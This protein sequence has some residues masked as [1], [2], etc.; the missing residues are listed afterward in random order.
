MLAPSSLL[1]SPTDLRAVVCLSSA[2][3]ANDDDVADDEDDCGTARP[4]YPGLQFCAS[5]Y[6]DRVYLYTKVPQPVPDC[7]KW[8]DCLTG[9]IRGAKVCVEDFL[10]F[11]LHWW[12]SLGTVSLT[13]PSTSTPDSITAFEGKQLRGCTQN[14]DLYFMRQTSG[15]CILKRCQPLDL[16]A[17]AD[18]MVLLLCALSAASFHN[19][20]MEPFCRHQSLRLPISESCST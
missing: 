19:S 18:M 20:N 3:D 16:L 14:Y 6:T 4:V 5:Q 9:L 17:A 10:R 13:A 11:I 1:L 8:D 7:T 2:A 15:I 12:E